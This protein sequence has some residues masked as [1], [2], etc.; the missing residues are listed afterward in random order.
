MEAHIYTFPPVLRVSM[1]PL[2]TWKNRTLMEQ[3]WRRGGM[4]HMKLLV[5]GTRLGILSHYEQ[6]EILCALD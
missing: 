6:S 1:L 3:R 4:E 2:N 5:S